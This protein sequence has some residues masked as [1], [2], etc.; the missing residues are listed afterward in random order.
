MAS[1]NPPRNATAEQF[2]AWA[3]ATFRADH[4]DGWHTAAISDA[5]VQMLWHL[6]QGGKI[7]GTSGITQNFDGHSGDDLAAAFTKARTYHTGVT[8]DPATPEGIRY[9][10]PSSAAPASAAGTPTT[11]PPATA[12]GG[13]GTP[14][15]DA[16]SGLDAISAK[17][18]GFAAFLKT[19]AGQQYANQLGGSASDINLW[20]SS[21]DK[22]APVLGKEQ[23]TVPRFV[24]GSEHHIMGS[25]LN[26]GG[27]GQTVDVSV[28]SDTPVTKTAGDW[29]QGLYTMTP[30]QLLDLQHRL[31][32]QG[33]YVSQKITDFGQL[34][35]GSPDNATIN[36]YGAV[37]AQAARYTAVGKRIGIDGVIDLG[38]PDAATAKAQGQPFEKTNPA[39]LAAGLRTQAQQELGRYATPAETAAFQQQYLGQEEAARRE[40][41]SAGIANRTEGVTG[42]ASVSGAAQ[43]FIDT[44]AIADRIAYGAAQRQNEFYAM[45]KSP[46]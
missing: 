39:D 27:R 26:R 34:K 19:P 36:A 25:G 9:V 10:L 17:V 22:N 20:G 46:V 23:T 32:D 7:P 18:P 15:P 14:A 43:Q 13:G 45:L 41:I 38:S 6:Y 8:D 21:L 12:A 35:A 31:W 16:Q 24:P 42:P 11:A 1:A 29:L 5:E 40:L 3:R 28:I 4:G 33:W 44:N 30:A 2:A 37:L